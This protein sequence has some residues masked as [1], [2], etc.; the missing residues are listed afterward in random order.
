MRKYIYSLLFSLVMSGAF[1]QN[2]REIYMEGL[3]AYEAKN[4]TA[5][6]DKMLKVDSLRPNYPAVVYNIAK[7]Y[8]LTGQLDQS[9]QTLNKYLLM[10][11]MQEFSK[12]SVFATLSSNS[13]FSDVVQKVESL[14]KPI[15]PTQSLSYEILS[16]HPESMAYDQKQKT[17]YMGGVRDGHIYQ[18][19]EGKSPEIWA[20]SS[21]KSW[22]IMGLALSPDGK[23]LWACTSSMPNYVGFDQNEEGYVSVL[24]YDLKNGELLERFVMTGEHNFGDLIIDKKGNV[25]ISDGIANT[26]YKISKKQNELVPFVDLSNQVFNLQGLTFDDQEQCMYLSDYIDGIY[27]LD[28]AKLTVTKLNTQGS[29][30]LLKGIDGLY[31]QGNSLIGLH[32]GTKPNRVVRYL[33]SDDGNALVEKEVLVQDGD[34][35]EPTQGVFINDQFHFIMNSPWG[36]YDEDSN[37]V[38]E[39]KDIKIG[40]LE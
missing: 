32:N 22:S 5:F 35:G 29:D 1:G 8:A 9:V 13:L 15:L 38:P 21:Q 10:D 30:I 14:Q 4:Y 27:K 24:K 2:L 37:F 34:L 33:L 25:Y 17:I 12:D 19:K 31:M 18:L 23:Y 16:A 28:M 6:L 26:V 3:S 7:G 36:S 20:E 11:A 39:G 40:I